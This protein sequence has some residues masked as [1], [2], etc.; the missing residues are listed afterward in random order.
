MNNFFQSKKWTAV[1]AI[2]FILF[3]V[4]LIFEAGVAVGIHKA[5]YADRMGGDYY[6]AFGSGNTPL[7]GFDQ[8]DFPASHGVA[9]TIIKIVPPY[10]FIQGPD[11]TERTIR[12]DASTT[13]LKYRDVIGPGDLS[14]GESIVVIGTPAT[15]SSNIEA[16]FVRVMPSMASH[17]PVANP[18]TTTNNTN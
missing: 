3:V 11:N 15:S 10:A 17:E 18:S 16:R 4:L 9:G 6:R 14:D 12:I 2:I 7:G 1:L 5:T 8:D 13:I